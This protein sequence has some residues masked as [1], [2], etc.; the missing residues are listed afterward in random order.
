MKRLIFAL[1]AALPLAVYGERLT[2]ECNNEFLGS[3][4]AVRVVSPAAQAS[5]VTIVTDPTTN[6]D[7]YARMWSPAT[8][9]A[10]TDDYGPQ[11]TKRYFVALPFEHVQ[12]TGEI[13]QAIADDPVLRSLGV[14]DAYA[15]K[16]S[17]CFAAGPDPREVTITE[18]FNVDLNHYFL[19]S[20]DEENAVIDTGGA[21]PGWTRTGETFKTL[22]SGPFCR[23]IP[24]VFR[25]YTYGANSHFFTADP[26][27]CGSLRRS[28]PGWIYE[29]AAFGAE[30]PV[31]GAC[32]AGTTPLYRLYN[33][34]WMYN[35]SNHRFVSRQ[36]LRD[37]MVAKG[38]ID[39]GVAMCLIP[40][41]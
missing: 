10:Q 34:R 37:K 25:F 14:F 4:V 26:L 35:D 29:G 32:P 27:E 19:S 38:W 6:P 1:A 36:D 9:Y 15:S 40:R 12:D 20:S 11:R 33:N 18:Y 39:E 24:P 23:E 31:D 13:G 3:E 7:A 16:Y 21:G 5:L 22:E 30:M 8:A 2:R 17:I 28:D 41:Y